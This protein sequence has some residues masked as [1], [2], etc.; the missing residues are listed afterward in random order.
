MH[1]PCSQVWR[2]GARHATNFMIN[3]S[4]TRAVFGKP[5]SVSDYTTTKLRQA[6]R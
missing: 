3:E 4:K 5:A 1:A 6:G 2:A